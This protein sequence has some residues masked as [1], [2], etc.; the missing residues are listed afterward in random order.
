MSEE[1]QRQLQEEFIR[2]V[3]MMTHY[4][5]LLNA[6]D[7][8]LRSRWRSGVLWIQELIERECVPVHA[9]HDNTSKEEI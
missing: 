8:G 1:Q 5:W 2:V 4:A 3:R 9:V 7:G 6:Y